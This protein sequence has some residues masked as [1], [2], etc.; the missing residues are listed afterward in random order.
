MLPAAVIDLN[1]VERGN[2]LM[3]SFDTPP[4]T[5]DNLPIRRFSEIELRIGPAMTPFNYAK[6]ED[7]ARS[8]DLPVPPRN[9]PDDPKPWP[10]SKSIPVT[11][12]VGKRV[13]I[14]VRTAVKENEHFS[15]WSNVVRLEIVPP[16]ERPTIAVEAT[17]QGVQVTWQAEEGEHYRVLRRGL[18]DKTPVEI[19]TSKT[20][21]YI[22]SNA[23][24]ET[25]YEYE[26]VALKGAAES[27]PSDPAGI[28]PVD[29]FPPS[30]PTGIA[31]LPAPDSIELSWQRSPEADLKGYYV[32]RSIN[33]GPF[34]RQGDLQNLPVYSDRAV[35]HGKTYRYEI[36]AVDQKG[37]ESAKSPP[38]EAA[39]Q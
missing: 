21:K 4:R 25:H 15:A 33:D 28:T 6:W 34:E 7:A 14:A 38:V 23:Q 20:A 32:Y 2:Q 13:A 10:I 35:E 5:T 3:I 37:N 16:L 26:V 8:F 22:D 31:A 27:L 17:A 30:V 1:V 29:V 9:D 39:F 12:W 24:Y 19:G 36:S 18:N 11:D